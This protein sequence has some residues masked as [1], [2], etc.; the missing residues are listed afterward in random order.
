MTFKA[1]AFGRRIPGTRSIEMR[2]LCDVTFIGL[3]CTYTS[4]VWVL[5]ASIE[6]CRFDLA[7]VFCSFRYE[8]IIHINYAT[9]SVRDKPRRT[10]IGI[11]TDRETG[12][13]TG[14]G[15]GKGTGIGPGRETGRWAGRGAGRGTERYAEGQADG[16]AEGQAAR[17]AE[18]QA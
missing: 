6:F 12:R 17:Q 9:Q 5:H 1:V 13:V 2:G 4:A 7:K 14:R 8:L 10:V 3:S 18:E 11:G 16:Q 15:T